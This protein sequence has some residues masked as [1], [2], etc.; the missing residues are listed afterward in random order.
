MTNTPVCDPH[1]NR[2]DSAQVMVTLKYLISEKEDE[3]LNVIADMVPWHP[4][5]AFQE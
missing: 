5:Q 1:S 4:L 2:P 3:S